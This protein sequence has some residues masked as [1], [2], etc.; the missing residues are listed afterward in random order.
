MTRRP[1]LALLLAAC[2]AAPAVAPAQTPSDAGQGLASLSDDRLLGELASRNLETL[3][4]RAF[5]N[6]AVPADQQKALLVRVALSRL[7]DPA[8]NLSESERN[9]LVRRVSTE[10][11][12]V[13]PGVDDP[14]LLMEQASVLIQQG[15]QSDV[16]RLEY[17]GPSEAVQARL[18]P[19]VET[20]MRLLDKTGTTA[21]ARADA[22][23]EK[24][25]GPNDQRNIDLTEQAE[26]LGRIAD[27]TADI[28]GYYLALALD[29]ADPRRAAAAQQS[30]DALTVYDSADNP[31]RNFVRA[32]LGKLQTTRGTADGFD[33]ARGQFDAVTAEPGEPAN[34]GV[35]FDAHYGRAVVEL[36]AGD[37]AAARA[38]AAAFDDWRKQ[39]LP[40]DDSATA[41]S[42]ILQYRLLGAEARAATDDAGRKAANDRAVEVLLDLIRRRPDLQGVIYEQLLPKVKGADDVASLDP[43]LL[44]ALMSQGQ[45][46]Y[47]K[48]APDA[49]KLRQGVAAAREIVKR[50][51]D[52][53]ATGAAATVDGQL[54]ANA[55][56]LAPFLLEKLGQNVEAADGYL[57]FIRRFG[58]DRQKAETALNNAQVLVGE[59][60]KTRADDPAVV[61]VFDRLLPVAVS[62]PFNRTEL[63]FLYAYRQQRLGRSA[64]AAKF[65]AQ[66]PAGDPNYESA[67]YFRMV[68]LA[69]A[70]QSLPK[71]SAERKSA[72]AEVQSLADRVK[73][74]A[75]QSLAVAADDRA[76]Q[77]QRSRLVR[78]SLLAADLARR[79]QDDP[80]RA[81]A[82]LDGFERQVEGL[83]EA[84]ALLGEALFVRVQALTAAG[85][86]DRAVAALRELLDRQGG[87]QGLQVVYELLKKL[88]ADFDAADA[89]GDDAAK[90]QL[91]A[92][93]ATLTPFL[94]EYA[95]K[96]AD[97]ATAELAYQ[98]RV[99]DADTQRIAADLSADPAEQK[100][101]REAALAQFQTLETPENFKR[102]VANLP[103]AQ[104]QDA[105]YDPVVNLGLARLKYALGDYADAR[106][107]FA[108]LIRDK[109][110]GDAY[111]PS[112]AAGE[113]GLT[114]NPLY[115]EAILK[116]LRSTEKAG[117]L[118]D[119]QKVFL[120]TQYVKY[121]GGVGGQ[122][123][124]D[125]Y[126]RLREDV[127]PDFDPKS[128]AS[129]S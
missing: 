12:A 4:Q 61:A 23:A 109:A 18:R 117:G 42:Q 48:D 91:A 120:K 26:N 62:E 121:P 79:E 101:L 72:L 94:V 102:Y 17:W 70:L 125:E 98:Y 41:I 96:S 85:Q 71:G 97:P 2:L 9:D 83:P 107:R 43:L 67:R 64:E 29:P 44:K 112:A 89:R 54:A 106:N 50:Y 115:W 25:A 74:S 128:V 66:V 59:L 28:A 52:G 34:L 10:I 100:R 33:A 127:I 27:Y 129:A 114:S 111:I 1:R 39:A 123:Y 81:I 99:L 53:S 78:T 47:F 104:R 32:T 55:A 58:T 11:D 13:L 75:E 119:E 24:I 6:D 84:N 76:K 15:V 87:P 20:V 30:I 37:V 68:A 35:Q 19:V 65:Y 73:R 122:R 49:D 77:T 36:L 124:A 14:R 92:N 126:E 22:A 95:D 113:T 38:Q 46:E 40:D 93:R 80:Q 31:D 5:A 7:A 108:N 110:V 103:P 60:R 51:G 105:K 8:A 88:D 3:L 118:T 16:Q 56:F 86:T 69:D 63:A 45:D 82:L 57:D 21:K 90:R 116:W